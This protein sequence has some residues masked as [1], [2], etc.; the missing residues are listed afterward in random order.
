[1]AK[2][3]KL[4]VESLTGNVGERSYS[5][6]PPEYAARRVEL[7]R[8]EKEAR[9][10]LAKQKAGTAT[11]KELRRLKTLPREIKGVTLTDPTEIFYKEKGK[12]KYLKEANWKIKGDPIEEGLK[13]LESHHKAGLDKYYKRIK[14]WGDDEIFDLHTD[15]AAQDKYLGNHPKNRL[16]LDSSLHMGRARQFAPGYEGIHGAITHTDL[17]PDEF[18]DLAYRMDEAGIDD[19]MDTDFDFDSDIG[20]PGDPRAPR[21]QRTQLRGVEDFEFGTPDN[22]QE[23]GRMMD[24]DYQLADEFALKSPKTKIAFQGKSDKLSQWI[25]RNEKNR[26]FW[27][28]DT[29]QAI[30][31]IDGQRL[32]NI[33]NEIQVN[34][35]ASMMEALQSGETLPSWQR[36]ARG[37][38][39]RVIDTT[40]PLLK[41]TTGLSRAESAVRIAGGDYIGGAAGLA[42]TTPTFQKQIGKLLAKQGIKMIPGVSFGSGALQAAGYLSKGQWTKAGLSAIG[43]VVGELGPAGD[44]VQAAIDLGLTGHDVATGDINHGVELEDELEE[45]KLLKKS[46]N[47][48][49]FVRSL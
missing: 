17:L 26:A 39:N 12:W 8:L 48:R 3:D 16:Q 38:V 13:P 33:E 31:N 36:K 30:E 27:P 11:P 18:S 15:L 41:T 23:I 40:S 29:E 20:S 24:K 44:A 34:K 42:M 47:L 22:I 14:G 7:R 25:K 4:D 35:S 9:T 46:K 32:G 5:E 10:L 19:Y 2:K 45:A 6:L 43:G 1:M 49:G 21:R 37:V 28:A